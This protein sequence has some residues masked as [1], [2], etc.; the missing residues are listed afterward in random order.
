MNIK[1]VLFLKQISCYNEFI[2]IFIN[3]GENDEEENFKK[4]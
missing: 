4:Y 1:Q 2:T 3:K